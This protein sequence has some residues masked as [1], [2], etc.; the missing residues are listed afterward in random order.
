MSR[1]RLKFSFSRRNYFGDPV[2]MGISAP[3]KTEVTRE[4]FEWR[5]CSTACARVTRKR[6][7]R[8]GGDS[9]HKSQDARLGSVALGATSDAF[10]R[11]AVR[12]ARKYGSGISYPLAIRIYCTPDAAG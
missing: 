6:F 1:R 8:N 9:R 4:L 7:P 3:R 12:A 10:P 2:R 5:S 11:R